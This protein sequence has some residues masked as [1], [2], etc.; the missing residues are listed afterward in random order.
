MDGSESTPFRRV[1]CATCGLVP[2]D[3]SSL[4]TAEPIVARARGCYYHGAISGWWFVQS[5]APGI[6]RGWTHLLPHCAF[7]KVTGW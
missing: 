3:G 1:A 6:A 7:P 2:T 5:V 4:L